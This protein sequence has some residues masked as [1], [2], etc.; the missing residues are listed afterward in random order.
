MKIDR[1]IT[2]VELVNS[3]EELNK[4][5]EEQYVLL[6]ILK[7]RDHDFDGYVESAQYLIGR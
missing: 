7:R 3:I 5:L 2:H 6:E 4:K 1:E